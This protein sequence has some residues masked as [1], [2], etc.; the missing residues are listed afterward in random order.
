[1]VILAKEVRLSNMV[2]AMVTEVPVDVVMTSNGLVGE[3][4][5]AW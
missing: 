3:A 2:T 5:G 1:M 4:V